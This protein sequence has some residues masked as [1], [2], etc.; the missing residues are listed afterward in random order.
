MPAKVLI[1]D[2]DRRLLWAM[3]VRLERLG[4]RC[5]VCSNAQ[6]AM[7][8]FFADRVDLVITDMTMPGI[9][10]LGV[11]GMIRNQSDVPI[12]VVTGHADQ[13]YQLIARFSGIAII[14]KPFAPK[15][16]E[17]C[18]RGVIPRVERVPS[19]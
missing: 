15:L 16:L 6:E 3:S 12:I 13:Y 18:V 8:H 17:E 1:I 5:V 7:A 4:C 10:G 11:V 2:D 14:R 19:T 9:D